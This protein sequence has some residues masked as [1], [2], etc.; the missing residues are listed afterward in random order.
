[1]IPSGPDAKAAFT[2]SFFDAVLLQNPK[3]QTVARAVA[4]GADLRR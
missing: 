4:T 3:P 1:M 2:K